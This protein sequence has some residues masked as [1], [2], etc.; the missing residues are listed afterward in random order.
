M[1]IFLIWHLILKG[2]VM[3][4]V[5][6]ETKD[7]IESFTAE[8]N[9]LLDDAES[10][11]HILEEDDNLETIN[12]IFR[13]FHTIKGTAGYLNFANINNLTHTAETLLDIFRKNE[14][15]KPSNVDID[16]I[17]LACDALRKLIETAEKKYTDEGFEED[18]KII[19]ESINQI[20]NSYINT[21]KRNTDKK[22]ENKS[23]DKKV[24]KKGTKSKTEKKKTKQDPEEYDDLVDKEIFDK[25]ISESSGLLEKVEKDLL[26]LEK[27]PTNKE[28]IS[29]I[30]RDIHTIK[31]NAGFLGADKIEKECM[32]LEE[33][34][35]K[36]RND[37][38]HINNSV[39]SFLLD[40]KDLIFKLVESF[41]LDNNN[42]EDEEE[43][44]KPLGEI[45][46]NMG[47]VSQ[48]ALDK[49]LN[50]QQ[51]RVGEI[52]VTQGEV[53]ANDL[54]KALDK[55]GAFERNEALASKR[56][57][58][59]ISTEKLDKLFELTGELITAESM[60]VNNTTIRKL[61][62]PDFEK[63]ANYLSKIT[64]E[65]QE[66]AMTI[67]MIPLEGIFTKSIRLVRDLSRKAKKKVNLQ[68][69]GEDTEMDRKIIEELS[70]PLVHII[71][72]SIDHGIE[73]TATRKKNN[74]NEIAAISLSAKYE[75]NEVWIS[76]TDD[77][78]GLDR[79]KIL[80]KAKEKGLYKGKGDELTDDQVWEF[81]FKPGFSTADKITDVSGRGVG[82][83]VV[84]KNIT[85]LKG[86]I[87][88]QS[89]KNRGTTIIL[90]IP[91]TVAI[92]D[93]IT[94]KVAE[95]IYSIP[96]VDIIEFFQARHDQ[97]TNMENKFE[98]IK[99]R[100]EV[101]PI[102]KLYDFYKLK[103]DKTNLSEGIMVVVQREDK[104]AALFIED[105]LGSQQVVIKSLSDNFGHSRGVSGCS[106]LGNGDVSLIVDTGSLINE[107]IE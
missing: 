61:D 19:V 78:K 33:F 74:K 5:D 103:T 44:Y 69:S 56:K 6:Q 92:L 53:K 9:D 63:N 66:V 58:V 25:F 59:R 96:T 45:L 105:I 52:L 36:L 4:Q 100:N 106:I 54:K 14:N 50:V 7:L 39:I 35:D 34:L 75:G 27:A 18:I 87:S 62:I 31:G 82:M 43:E 2:A 1:R 85:K 12:T 21:D 37:E 99:L 60:V 107:C 88:I 73:D 64:R 84:Y 47:V 98:I 86:K 41:S 89:V 11:I 24:K 57:D 80:K 94:V 68:I 23:A 26:D 3:K 17:Y 29:S 38:R 70:D 55:Q 101:I 32:K 90:K 46:L 49:A 71:R 22:Q 83:D 42:E 104:K 51:S 10:K 81:I 97:I 48:D 20:I 93:V 77:G 16:V 91:L 15:I 76:I 8:S 28:I 40:H 30:F 13:A 72:N 67:R 65:L 95:N 79:E 102:I